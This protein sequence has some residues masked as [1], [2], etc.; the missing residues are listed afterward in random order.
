MAAQKKFSKDGSKQSGLEDF[1][2]RGVHVHR[3]AHGL[4]AGLGMGVSPIYFRGRPSMQ[5]IVE[6]LLHGVRTIID[7][8]VAPLK[9]DWGTTR[10]KLRRQE[11]KEAIAK[12]E[13]PAYTD[14]TS[15][16]MAQLDL[17]P[18][19]LN[20]MRVQKGDAEAERHNESLEQ[21]S[22]ESETDSDEEA[23]AKDEDEL[24]ERAPSIQAVDKVAML[25]N[26]G[27]LG[28][29]DYVCICTNPAQVRPLLRY[30]A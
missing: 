6:H 2:V 24:L 1:P 27:L 16:Q 9:R 5:G 26:D 12:E 3:I 14:I 22:S 21:Q 30:V 20:E 11:G 29:F 18:K 17:Q 10:Y 25:Q 8:H 15:Y 28:E 4:D 13:E 7:A 19:T 23:Q